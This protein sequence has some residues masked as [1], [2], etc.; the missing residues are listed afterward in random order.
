[1]LRTNQVPYITKTLRKAILRRYNCKQNTLKINHRAIIYYLKNRNI[2]CSKL[3]K[4]QINKYYDALDI[5]NITDNKQFWKT[6]K[7]FLSEKSK[8]S[9]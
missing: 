3:Y 1:M 4:T 7:S 5:K 2:F 9:S 6:S 8:T